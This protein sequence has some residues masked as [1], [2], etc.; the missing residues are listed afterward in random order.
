[1]SSPGLCSLLSS[2]HSRSAFIVLLGCPLLCPSSATSPS[3]S[4]CLVVV[5]DA[6]CFRVVEFAE[7]SRAGGTVFCRE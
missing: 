1:M 3:H 2:Y 6:S 7:V 4:G 5:P